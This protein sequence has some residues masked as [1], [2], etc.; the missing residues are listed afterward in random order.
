MFA[1]GLVGE[2]DPAA[3]AVAESPQDKAKELLIN[4]AKETG[5]GVVFPTKDQAASEIVRL[6]F[7]SNQRVSK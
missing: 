3:T 6:M 4:I 2:L 5:G 7:N 1:I